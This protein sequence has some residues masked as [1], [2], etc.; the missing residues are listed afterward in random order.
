M[1]W[2]FDEDGKNEGKTRE[3][4]KDCATCGMRLTCGKQKFN[5]DLCGIGIKRNPKTLN[6]EGRFLRF[7]CDYCLMEYINQK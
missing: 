7:C 1:N 6:K 3:S 5:C 4:R 2:D